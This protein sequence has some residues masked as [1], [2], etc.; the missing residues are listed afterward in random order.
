MMLQPVFRR[1][2]PKMMVHLDF[3]TMCPVL[4]RLEM[5]DVRMTPQAWWTL[6]AH[7]HLESL[8]LRNM[9]V[10]AGDTQVF[11]QICMQLET[12][13]MDNVTFG[14]SGQ[15]GGIVPKDKVFDR[16]R[17]FNLRRGFEQFERQPI[18]LIHCLPGVE[19]MTLASDLP[20]QWMDYPIRNHWPQIKS[21]VLTGVQ[22]S[23]LTALLESVGHGLASLTFYHCQ[24]A[25]RTTSTKA[26]QTHFKTLVELR[27]HPCTPV[28]SETVLDV[29]CACPV[30]EVL[31]VRYLSAEVITGR[32]PW[33]CQQHLRELTAGIQVGQDEEALQPLVF[34]RLSTLT[35]L[36]MLE[37]LT[38]MPNSRRSMLAFRL[39]CGLGQLA[40]WQHLS[41]LQFSMEWYNINTPQ[42]GMDEV[43]WMAKHWK[44]LR[45]VSGHLHHDM[46]MELQLRIMFESHGIKT[47]PTS[48]SL[49]AKSRQKTS[50]V[51][52][53]FRKVRDTVKVLT[54]RRGRDSTN[55]D[56]V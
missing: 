55:A 52:N 15:E 50:R 34:E 36:E 48:S 51:H 6:S 56:A 7:P 3:L 49:G 24:L 53:T 29:L 23:T 33:A 39:E 40:H 26:L 5:T 8:A 18:E 35:R 30:L 21:L 27:I 31:H 47:F 20:T 37:I 11:W 2:G 9:Q 54:R 46:E 10:E 45:S 28:S 32:G 4:R 43:A 38:P 1:S 41:V 19:S 25:T 14:G 22:E 13:K 12:L 42:V 16:I 17:T 44:K